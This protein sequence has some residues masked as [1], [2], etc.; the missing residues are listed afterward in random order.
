MGL[1]FALGRQALGRCKAKA[2]EFQQGRIGAEMMTLV[3][4]LDISAVAFGFHS[5]RIVR[6]I[7][8]FD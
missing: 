2:K 8:S 1:G 4:V 5:T 3:K 6:R 7:A